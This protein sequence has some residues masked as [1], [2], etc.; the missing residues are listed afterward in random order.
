MSQQQQ[1]KS[2]FRAEGW[3][4]VAIF[5]AG[6]LIGGFSAVEVVPN[7]T[8]AVAAGDPALTEDGS[9]GGSVLDGGSG[10]LSGSAEGSAK[11]GKAASG[12]A[13]TGGGSTAAAGPGALPPARA[14]L[15]CSSDKNG[16]ETDTG[17]TA[18]EI[19]MATTVAESGI[20]AS[21]LGEVRIGMDA[22]KDK[23]NRAGGFCGRDLVIQ[24]VD[25][26]WDAQRGAQY[27][28]NF[29]R[30]GV[31]GIPVG[32]SSEGLR[33]VIDSGDIDRAGIPVIGTDGML[34]D[35]YTRP[36]GTAQRW[37]WPVAAATVSSARI[38]CLDAYKRGA[39]NFSIVFDKNYR[40]GVEAAEAFNSC[41]RE[42]TGKDIGG[43]NKQYSCQESFCGVLAGQ[44]SYSSDVTTFQP[45]DYVALFLEPDTAQKWMI[46]PN[47]PKPSA[48]KNGYGGAQPLFTRSFA[49]NCQSKCDG[50]QIW[51]GFKPPIEGYANDPAVRTYVNDL[52][53]TK[54][55][56]DEY[57]A[58]TQGGY[59]GMLL[60]EDALKRVGPDVTRERLKAAL[61]TTCLA[62]GL[63]IQSKI[64]FSA[65]SRFA[66]LT[67]QSFAIQYRGTFGGWRAGRIIKDPGA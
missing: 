39:R 35:Q 66:N 29:I 33:I 26:G 8:G 2:P 14:G 56:A 17:V 62:T 51:T 60:L 4:A 40:F 30:E 61:D 37:V 47:T 67:M 16:G 10:Q 48:I 64:C 63:T 21:F 15:E 42:L 31:F 9:L 55:D 18:S 28:R 43:Y 11:G 13:A 27:L 5:V 45:G 53:R 65:G 36:D 24:Y 32:P 57:N 7:F 54:P 44:Q 34:Q 12:A 22:V 46:D 1:T 23:I 52:N 20:G 25:D 6:A 41:V 19:K 59:V 58:F 3:K 50:M 38:M 49:V